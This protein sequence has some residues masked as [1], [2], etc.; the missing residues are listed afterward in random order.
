M[1]NIHNLSVSF[2]GEYLFQEISFRLGAG[3]RIGLIG[4]NG[5]GKSTM[6]KIIA[7]E[8]EYD[9]GQ[10]AKDK[11]LR[12]GFLK[13]DIDFVQGR[14]VLDEAYQAFEEI[15]SLEAKMN[16]INHQLATRTDYESDS[17]TELIQE[18]T[19]VTHQYEI[20]GGYNYEGDT[21]KVLLGLGF[22]REDFEKLTDTFSGGW[23]MRI[24]LAKLLLQNNDI[25]LLDEPTNHLDIESI[26]WLESFLNSYPGCVILVSHDK[27]FLDN[28]TNRTIEISLGRIYDYKK[29]YSKYLELR[30]ELR[31]QQLA[32]Q[33]NQQKEIEQTEKLIEK[34]RAKASKASM[35]Q[36]LIKKLDKV[37]RIEV[38]EDDNAVMNISFPV[39]VQPGKVVVEAEHVGKAY[40]KH[41]VLED[42]NLLIERGSKIAFVGQNGQGKTT[43]AKIIIDEISHSG[44]LKLGHNVQLGYFAQN[45]ADYLDGEKS[46]YDTMVDAANESN[47]AKVRDMLGSFLFRGDEVDKKVKVLS[48]GERNRLALCKMLLQ[49]FNVLVMDEPTNHLDIKSKNVL[50]EACKNF[51]GTLIIVSH[52]RDFLQGL[53]STVYEFRN[54]K[55]KEYLGDI[56]YYL[57]QRKLEDMR[58]VEKRDKVP[59]TAAKKIATEKQ[60]YE[61][62]K[63]LKGLHN[64]LSKIESKISKIEKELKKKDQELATNYEK[65]IAQSNFLDSYN[66]KKKHLKS[67]MQEW[68]ELQLEIEEIS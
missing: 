29:P 9:S 63:K 2:Q 28:V 40:G 31:A 48:G 34:F 60:S 24:E 23:R 57:E 59:K 45:Q 18:L 46:I 50:K 17:Y 41:Q 7:G 56:D 37:N 21:E 38:D 32:A 47:R 22:K 43:L 19:D 51:E 55:I 10:I 4:K 54:K 61:D 27:M 39:S 6:L 49:P 35:A 52:D 8:Q 58:A 36:S 66:D 44:N 53:T 12:I 11:D 33:K 1:L 65:T 14:N 42:I 68:E 3:D 13:Q 67:L 5:A 25:L 20:I 30:G 15:K 16:D 62:Q 64:K 26:I